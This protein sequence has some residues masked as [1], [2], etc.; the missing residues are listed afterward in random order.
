[1]IAT[2]AIPSKK[3]ATLM[4][5][6]A[7]RVDDDAVVYTDTAH[8]YGKLPQ[9]HETVNHYDKVYV[10]AWRLCVGHEAPPRVSGR[11]SPLARPLGAE[12]AGCCISSLTPSSK[13]RP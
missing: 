8:A 1:L 9:V 10:A 11:V 6:I 12:W 3:K 7:R 5:H 13:V 4:G 2:H